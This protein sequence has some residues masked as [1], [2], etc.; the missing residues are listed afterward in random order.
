MLRRDQASLPSAPNDVITWARFGRGWR[1]FLR[2]GVAGL[3]SDTFQ[4]GRLQTGAV[5]KGYGGILFFL[6]LIV[7]T[8]ISAP[9]LFCFLY[10]RNLEKRSFT[11]IP[12]KYRSITSSVM[13]VL[14]LFCV[15]TS[16][17]AS[18]RANSS[19]SDALSSISEGTNGIVAE[20][21]KLSLNLRQSTHTASRIFQESLISSF[22]SFPNSVNVS[23]LQKEVAANADI[24]VQTLGP[25]DNAY[26]TIISNANQLD[27]LISGLHSKIADLNSLLAEIAVNLE[28]I[29]GP[30][31]LPS[32]S[33]FQLIS[34][35]LNT[36]TAATDS[37]ISDNGL[38]EA[39]LDPCVNGPNSTNFTALI[40]Q[41]NFSAADLF[42]S[43]SGMI[44][45]N[46][47]HINDI[48]NSALLRNSQTVYTSLLPIFRAFFNQRLNNSM[49]SSSTI[50]SSLAAFSEASNGIFGAKGMNSDDSARRGLFAFFWIIYTSLIS[51]MIICSFFERFI[52]LKY[53]D[54]DLFHVNSWCVFIDARSSIWRRLCHVSR[55]Q[56]GS[57]F[58]F[59]SFLGKLDR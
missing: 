36:A 55:W 49:Q 33:S 39:S 37:Q 1:L 43:T 6:V 16:F 8:G 31:V 56:C 22:S 45:S 51:A 53:S 9:P 20:M 52:I 47:T 40:Q 44:I 13:R 30:Q 29:N 23:G 3:P 42:F 26:S 10:R 4:N 17:I 34:P 57:L 28:T 11:W 12:L 48:L 2:G 5:L 7:L 14:V 59:G 19:L 24:L 50:N 18:F 25:F 27:R 41:S 54:T 38:L 32:G 46:W 15:S 35:I 21:D 58:W